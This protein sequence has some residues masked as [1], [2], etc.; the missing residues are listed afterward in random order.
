MS[1]FRRRLMFSNNTSKIEILDYLEIVSG[2]SNKF[3]IDYSDVFLSVPEKVEA[4]FYTPQAAIRTYGTDLINVCDRVLGQATYSSSQYKLYGVRY[5]SDDVNFRITE[6]GGASVNNAYF[7]IKFDT[8]AAQGYGTFYDVSTQSMPT[9][10]TTRLGSNYNGSD[11]DHTYT[12]GLSIIK[13]Q[14]GSY[15]AGVKFYDMKTFT[16]DDVVVNTFVPARY[17]GVYG[18]YESYTHV[19]YP[20]TSGF[21]CTHGSI[22]RTISPIQSAINTYKILPS[23]FEQDMSTYATLYSGTSSP[24]QAVNKDHTYTD[25]GSRFD[26]KTGS[27]AESFI[28]YKFDCSNVPESITIEGVE[29]SVASDISSTSN[30]YIPVREMQFYNGT[31]VAKGD[32][33]TITGTSR[34]VYSFD[35]GS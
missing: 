12:S 11:T 34:R 35:C 25:Y 23:S 21:T 24:T 4:S 32:S 22:L 30:T 10:A 17:E 31:D 13:N 9:S 16:A 8:F 7:K 27:G 18:I 5:R 2:V 33:K 15:L 29:A 26:L 28:F 6:H 19:F 3:L 14:N 1:D 20:I